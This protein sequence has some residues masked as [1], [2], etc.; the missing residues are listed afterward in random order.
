MNACVKTKRVIVMFVL[1]ALNVGICPSAQ[2]QLNRFQ[3]TFKSSN[4]QRII[5][6]VTSEYGVRNIYC[7]CKHKGFL[8]KRF[9]QRFVY[10]VR[11]SQRYVPNHIDISILHSAV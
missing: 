9:A 8:P 1:P 6:S 4:V 2:Q 7:N 3:R 10:T 11:M 5:S